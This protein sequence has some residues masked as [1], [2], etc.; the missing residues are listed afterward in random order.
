MK[1]IAPKFLKKIKE[2]VLYTIVTPNYLKSLTSTPNFLE[3]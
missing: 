2:I 1:G 3:K